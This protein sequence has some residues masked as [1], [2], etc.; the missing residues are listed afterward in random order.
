MF[1]ADKL[2]HKALFDTDIKQYFYFIMIILQLPVL[3]DD[4]PPSDRYGTY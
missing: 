3:E 2:D 1:T 4:E